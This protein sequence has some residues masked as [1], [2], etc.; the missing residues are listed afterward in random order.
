MRWLI[1]VGM[2]IATMAASVLVAHQSSA[3][4]ALSARIHDEL[5]PS[6]NSLLCAVTGPLNNSAAFEDDAAKSMLRGFPGP[7]VERNCSH[8][9]ITFYDKTSRC[10]LRGPCTMNSAW[11]NEMIQPVT[12]PR[13]GS[14]Q[15][16]QASL[17]FVRLPWTGVVVGVLVYIACK[18]RLEARIPSKLSPCTLRFGALSPSLVHPWQR[19]KYDLAALE[20]GL[21]GVFAYVAWALGCILAALLE[22]PTGLN[23][24]LVVLVPLTIGIGLAVVDYLK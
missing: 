12:L 20:I 2:V 18:V 8:D 22:I 3:V 10:P 15:R 9:I 11:Y 24:T 16:G 5:K 21:C 23:M 1:P 6:A 13:A 17:E 7:H 19:K 4:P 14:A